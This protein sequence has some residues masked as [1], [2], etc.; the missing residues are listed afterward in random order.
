MGLFSYAFGTPKPKHE[1]SS[2][3]RV[4]VH[5]PIVPSPKVKRKNHTH[6]RP[7]TTPLI[8]RRGWRR[9]GNNEWVGDYVCNKGTYNGHIIKRGDIFDVL[10]K[11][12]PREI[13]G[14]H[15]FVCFSRTAKQGWFNI[16]LHTQPTD[17]SPSTVI[18]YVEKLLNQALKRG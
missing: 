17:M 16:H 6:V 7:D 12:P 15:K 8:E 9:K 14:H 2:T 10:I 5:E 11:H 18:H 13:K 1:R 4:K 3:A